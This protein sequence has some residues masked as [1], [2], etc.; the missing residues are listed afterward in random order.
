[1]C[2]Y[3]YISIYITSS[4]SILSMYI[5]VDALAIVNSTSMNSGVHISFQIRVFSGCMLRII[6]YFYF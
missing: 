4:L 2:I 1:M 5:Q 6:W 3:L